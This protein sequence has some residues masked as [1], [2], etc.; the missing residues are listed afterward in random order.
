MK[1]MKIVRR[2]SEEAAQEVDELIVDICKKLKENMRKGEIS[3]ERLDA[4]AA[5]LTARANCV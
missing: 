1:E 2:I 5:L 4:L 3:S